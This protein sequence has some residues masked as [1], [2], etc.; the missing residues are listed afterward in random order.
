MPPFTNLRPTGEISGLEDRQGEEEIVTG[1]ELNPP[2]K[3]RS[4]M[5]Q[6]GK[7]D[8]QSALGFR[9]NGQKLGI[10]GIMTGHVGSPIG[11]DEDR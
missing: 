4:L 7:K 3:C 6:F 10:A 8:A 9:G 2:G 5:M 11:S 1:R